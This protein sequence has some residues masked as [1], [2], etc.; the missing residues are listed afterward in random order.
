MPLNPSIQREIGQDGLPGEALIIEKEQLQLRRYIEGNY[1]KIG[2]VQKELAHLSMEMKL[3]AGPT[4]A[5]HMTQ[6]FAF[7][8]VCPGLGA[9]HTVEK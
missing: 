5:G 6:L 7:V 3:T 1:S 4:R 9:I 2:D 8:I